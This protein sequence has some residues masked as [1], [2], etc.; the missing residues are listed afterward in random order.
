MTRR[1]TV[2]DIKKAGARYFIPGNR[3]VGVLRDSRAAGGAR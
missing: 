3:T 2:Q 1:I